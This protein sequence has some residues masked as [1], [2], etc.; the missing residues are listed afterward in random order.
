MTLN[1]LAVIIDGNRRW[2]RAKGLKPW[3]GHEEGAKAVDKFLNNCL[4]LGIKEITVY[5]LSTENLDRDPLELKFIFKIFGQYFKNFKKDKRISENGVKIKFAGDLSLIPKET[6]KIAAEVE[7]FTKD[8][9]K[10]KLN[11]CFAYGGRLELMRAFE[12]LRHKEKITEDDVKNA[13]WIGSDPD[14][15]I[16]TG[17]HKRLSGFLPWQSTYSELIFLEKMWPD[18]NK[19]DL[20]DCISEFESRKRNFG[21]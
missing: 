12:K 11:F 15:I 13:L 14:L 3:D 6:Q 7:E 2:A 10:R 9:S 16:R 4:E 17:G 18:F 19:Q 1:H 5:T 20:L 8:F 21:K